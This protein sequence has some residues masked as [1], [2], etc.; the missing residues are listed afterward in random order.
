MF[1]NPLEQFDIIF[2]IINFNYI[3]LI[4]LISLFCLFSFIKL[5][6][7]NVLPHKTDIQ[8]F[9]FI[10]FILILVSNFIIMMIF[11]LS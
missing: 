9:F 1:K 5:K 7:L 8:I 11:I 3:K 4:L 2:F 10:I 6:K